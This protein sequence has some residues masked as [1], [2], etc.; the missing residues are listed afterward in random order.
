M[1]HKLS[2]FAAFF[3]IVSLGALAPLLLLPAG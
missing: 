1:N 3:S 2:C